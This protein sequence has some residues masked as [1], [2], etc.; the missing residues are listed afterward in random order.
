MNYLSSVEEHFMDTC[1]FILGLEY[2]DTVDQMGCEPVD[3]G[4]EEILWRPSK[5]SGISWSPGEAQ[6]LS[7]GPQEEVPG[8]SQVIQLFDGLEA[9][10]CNLEHFESSVN[11]LLEV[12]DTRYEMDIRIAQLDVLQS[13]EDFRV[14]LERVAMVSQWELERKKAWE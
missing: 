7:G 8:P 2:R 12:L 13:L 3:I 14:I 4:G 6:G 9:H 11:W 5:K 1:C 10:A